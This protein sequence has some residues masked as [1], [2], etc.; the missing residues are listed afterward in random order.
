MS[1]ELIEE[2]TSVFTSVTT[3]HTPNYSARNKVQ[4]LVGC[5]KDRVFDYCSIEMYR[6]MADENG[7]WSTKC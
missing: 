4:K 1:Q 5:F 3:T 6:K 2:P 7:F